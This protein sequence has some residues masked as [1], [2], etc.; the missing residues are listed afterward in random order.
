LISDLSTGERQRFALARALLDD[1]RVLLL[2]EPC[3]SL[4]A[5]SAALVEEA[6]RYQMLSGRSIVLVS[7]VEGQIDR[8]AQSRLQLARLSEP[9]EPT[10][11]AR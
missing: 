2:D 4:D 9:S 5:V 8:L 1:A 11:W 10:E 7:H 6:M 3:A